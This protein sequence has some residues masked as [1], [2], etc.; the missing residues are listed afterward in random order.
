[1]LEL[2][3][4]SGY[5]VGSTAATTVTVADNDSGLLFTPANAALSVT[6]GAGAEY[7]VRLSTRPIGDV[8]VTVSGHASTDLSVDT[9]G[10]Q[11]GDQDTPHLH[12]V[13]LGPAPDG[14][15]FGPHRR[16]L[17]QRQGSR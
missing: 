13:Q 12:H 14:D 2:A 17:R 7:T 16:R 15:G 10:T 8:T 4:G 6:E 11:G 5:Q 3:D 9:D 1:M